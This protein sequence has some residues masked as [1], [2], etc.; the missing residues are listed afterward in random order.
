MGPGS[1]PGELQVQIVAKSGLVGLRRASTAR[2]DRPHEDCS[3]QQLIA[4]IR[5]QWKEDQVQEETRELLWNFDGID[6]SLYD[7]LEGNGWE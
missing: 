6:Y 4:D 1:E 3:D 5:E 2:W 7:L